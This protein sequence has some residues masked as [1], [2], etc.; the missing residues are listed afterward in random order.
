[1]AKELV[2]IELNED[3]IKTLV[4]EKY[5]LDVTETSIDIR[6]YDGDAR[7]R[8]YTSIVVTGKRPYN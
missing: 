5:N 7:E 3:D 1:M 8:S 4:A 6:K 2:R